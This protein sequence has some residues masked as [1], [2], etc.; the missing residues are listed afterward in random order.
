MVLNEEESV[1]STF[2][3]ISKLAWLGVTPAQSELS[4]STE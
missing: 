4:T 2:T 3:K 1:L